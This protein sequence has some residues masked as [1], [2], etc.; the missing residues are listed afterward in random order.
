MHQQ[1]D[2][3]A[4][5]VMWP[6]KLDRF[7]Q[8]I[9]DFLTYF[10]KHLSHSTRK[11]CVWYSSGVVWKC[12]GNSAVSFGTLIV[13]DEHRWWQQSGNFI[14]SQQ[15]SIRK[16]FEGDTR[17]RCQYSF[18]FDYYCPTLCSTLG[19][20]QKFPSRC[21]D[22]PNFW[23]FFL[24]KWENSRYSEDGCWRGQLLISGAWQF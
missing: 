2:T 10:R 5:N 22:D 24:T 13:D 1:L 12:V 19:A 11:R 16:M 17:C 3:S 14:I 8:F 9:L 15:K 6:F 23:Q 21:E 7:F 20:H 4:L 18:L